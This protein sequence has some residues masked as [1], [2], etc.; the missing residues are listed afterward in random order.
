MRH[1]TIVPILIMAAA[2]LVSCTTTADGALYSREDCEYTLTLVR[3]QTQSQAITRL[4]MDFNN[5]SPSFVPTEFAILE[6]K[7]NDIP[8]M[9]MLLSQW[10]KTVA[11]YLIS[12]YNYFSDLSTEKLNSLTF[13][14]PQAMIEQSDYSISTLYRAKW[15]KALE[16]AA[17][18]RLQELDLSSWQSI[19]TQ[20]NAWVATQSLLLTAK[21]NGNQDTPTPIGEHD[22]IK[23]VSELAIEL[24]FSIF[25]AQETL[26]RT[27]PNPDMDLVASRVL[28]LD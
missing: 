18:E 17:Y 5:Y 9:D 4:F 23:M 22:I 10:A 19:V 16:E 3:D 24:Y 1:K 8:G 6:Q 12:S 2:L 14:D 26:I 28:G 20:Y 15:T 7:R 11:D 27:T 13:I 25:E 21:G